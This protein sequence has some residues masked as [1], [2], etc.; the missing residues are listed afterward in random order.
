MRQ[1]VLFEL[2]D[3]CAKGNGVAVDMEQVLD[4]GRDAARAW[5]TLY[6]AIAASVVPHPP[7]EGGRCAFY[8]PTACRAM[9]QARKLMVEVTEASA[10]MESLDE[11]ALQPFRALANKARLWLSE[12]APRDGGD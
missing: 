3:C 5:C 12:H 7:H 11:K 10:K 2:A 1:H 8:S 6:P 9:A 4:I